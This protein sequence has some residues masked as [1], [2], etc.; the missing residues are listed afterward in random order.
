MR[1]KPVGC[2]EPSTSLMKTKNR[3]RQSASIGKTRWIGYAAAGAATALGGSQSA[4]AAIHYSGRLDVVFKGEELNDIRFVLDQPGNYIE[5]R[6]EFGTYA[7]FRVYTACSCERALRVFYSALHFPLFVSK[8][9]FGENISGG[10]FIRTY[11]DSFGH[12]ARGTYGAW[13]DRGAGFIGFRFH[14]SEGTQYG[15]ARVKMAGE[16]RGNAFKFID[17]AF[18]DPGEPIFAG[19]K[20]SDEQAPDQGSTDEVTPDEGSLGGLAL[21][22]TGLIAWRKRRSQTAR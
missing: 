22:A 16:D 15:W 18:A 9:P 21:G 4:E 5:L 2:L 1:A 6:H 19:Q 17:Y 12:L 14:G 13:L 11:T 3:N 7:A 8:L 20:S 10:D